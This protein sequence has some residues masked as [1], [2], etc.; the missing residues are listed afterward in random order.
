MKHLFSKSMGYII[1]ALVVVFYFVL[2]YLV[3]EGW[4]LNSATTIIEGS[5]LFVSAVIVYS[6][7]TKQGILNG[8]SNDK[9]IETV[10][11]HITTKQKIFPKVKY[12]QS[13][14]DKNYNQLMKIG[15]QTFVDSAGYDY[16]QVFTEDGKIVSDFK[17]EKPKPMEFK[18]KWWPPI[19]WVAKLGRFIWGED[20]KIYRMRKAFIRKAKH[21][22]ITRL[23]VSSVVNIDAE[24][25][26]NDFGITEKQYLKREN[27]KNIIFRFLFSF[28]L[29]SA[30][31]AFNGF[32]VETLF[33]Q[34]LSILLIIIS[35]LFSMFGSYFFIV[36]T[37]RGTIIKIVNKLEEFD[38]ADLTEFKTQKEKKDERICS[39]K[40]ICEQSNVVEEIQQQPINGEVDSLRGNT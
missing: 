39:E 22:K 14:L 5:L 20:W 15:R 27:S 23:T 36:R 38:N 16:S 8:R 9:Y 19:K 1:A 10:K 24:D 18:R 35:A 4:E 32:N 12:L 34:M 30:T 2:S 26:P 31:F 40:S 37:H 6:S 29:P 28:L 25:D 17:V 7:L 33:V 13:W 3:V 11:T 21:Y